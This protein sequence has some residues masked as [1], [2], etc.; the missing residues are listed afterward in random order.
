LRQK[1][2]KSFNVIVRDP[3]KHAEER[4]R[5]LYKEPMVV[6]EDLKH[7]I[8]RLT[9]PRYKIL[10]DGRQGPLPFQTMAEKEEYFRRYNFA[11]G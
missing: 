8:A 5:K 11:E 4:Y 2:S 9:W 3:N 6:Q 10:P 7:P 1:A